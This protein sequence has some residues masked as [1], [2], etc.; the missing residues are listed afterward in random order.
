MNQQSKSVV[1]SL[2]CL[3]KRAWLVLTSD[4]REPQ[5]VEMQ[6]RDEN[7]WSACATLASG[8][9]RCRYYSGDERNVMYQG[10]AH[11]DGSTD[12]GMDG[13]LS[14]TIPEDA[15]DPQIARQI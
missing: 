9:Y 3:E 11:I 2:A 13:L 7:I 10:P 14:V 5:V 1:F 4:S 15:S 6:R 12:G 8:K